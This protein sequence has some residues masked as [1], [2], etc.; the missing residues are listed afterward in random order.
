MKRLQFIHALAFLCLIGCAAPVEKITNVSLGMTKQE[1]I[2]TM[3][4]PNSTKAKDSTETL[5]YIHEGTFWTWGHGVRPTREYWVRLE[6][7]KVTQ[8]GQPSDFKID[9]TNSNN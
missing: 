4:P 2:G 7:G 9:Q 1:V 8:Y 6:N 5:V 3:G